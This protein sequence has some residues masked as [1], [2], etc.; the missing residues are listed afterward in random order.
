M[1]RISERIIKEVLEKQNNRCADCPRELTPKITHFDHILPR[2]D[3]GDDDLENIQ[4]LCANCHSNKTH[5]ENKKKFLKK[6]VKNNGEK[7]LPSKNNPKKEHQ[8]FFEAYNVLTESDMLSFPRFRE[9]TA[10]K[11]AEVFC[12]EENYSKFYDFLEIFDEL[13][14]SDMLSSPKFSGR[15][16]LKMA[17]RRVGVSMDLSF[18]N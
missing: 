11:I 14:E 1:V 5:T 2:W 3:G 13:T 12:K 4:A 10:K 6:K 17:L 18:L 15:D 7:I 9:S 16:A 8:R